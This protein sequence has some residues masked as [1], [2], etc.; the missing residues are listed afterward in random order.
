MPLADELEPEEM[1]TAA[2]AG[3]WVFALVVVVVLMFALYLGQ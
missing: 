1:P 2:E 3:A